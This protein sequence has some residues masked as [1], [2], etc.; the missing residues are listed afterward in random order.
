M[1][2][3]IDGTDVAVCDLADTIAQPLLPVKAGETHLVIIRDGDRLVACDRACPH[4]QADL[5][6]GRCQNG[7]LFCPRHYASFDLDTG[8][9]SSGWVSP[10]LRL[11]PVT[12]RQERVW[13]R[14]PRT[15]SRQPADRKSRPGSE[16]D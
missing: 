11:F 6:L 9:I 15:A 16:S 14:I 3:P 13:V 1:T 12:V 2:G 5:A 7:K 10:A 4:E 8:R